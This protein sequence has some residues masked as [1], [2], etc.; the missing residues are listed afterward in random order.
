MMQPLITSPH[1]TLSHRAQPCSAHRMGPKPEGEVRLCGDGDRGCCRQG[2]PSS[3]AEAG[4]CVV[5][6]AGVSGG[7]GQAQALAC[8]SAGRGSVP[9][10]AP[11]TLGDAG[12]MEPL[13]LLLWVLLVGAL[14]GFAH[15]RSLD[16]PRVTMCSKAVGMIPHPHQATLNTQQQRSCWHR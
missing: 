1:T 8:C 3:T 16:C 4:K 15:M 7:K 12:V 11:C 14:S 9:A 5:N 13:T 10:P 2:P 6:E